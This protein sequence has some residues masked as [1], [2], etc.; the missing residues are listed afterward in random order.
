MQDG[1]AAH[2]CRTNSAWNRGKLIGPKPPLKAKE[3][4]SIRVRLQ[5]AHL[6][7]DLALFNLAPDSK[8]RAC[9]LVTLRVDDVALNGRVRSRATVMQRKTGRLVQFEVTEQT[10][11]AVARW[12][13]KKDLHKG[14]PLFPSRINRARPMTTRQYT[15][16]LASWL[17]AI[18]LDP[19]AYG[20]HSLRRTKASM[21]YRRT[22]NLRAVQLLLG[23]TQI[24]STVRYLGID[25]DDA[26]LVAEQVEI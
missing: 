26:L 16:L 8:L 5:L 23:H 1:I 4:W 22:G 25:I 6:I 7:R 9:D 14:E 13:E 2:P 15:R 17:R 12:L 11:E 24:E 18:G 19:L 21:I 20:T 3:I 10:R